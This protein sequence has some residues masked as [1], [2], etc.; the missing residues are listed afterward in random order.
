M[1]IDAGPLI[2]L[3]D[4]SDHF[5]QQAISFV[6]FLQRPLVTTWPVVT[7]TSHMLSFNTNV[8]IAFLE[9]INRGGLQ[10][11][12]IDDEHASFN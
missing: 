8:Q 9:W 3:F 12:Q 2:A 10:I 5:H 6:R 1:L 7:E 4:R 11:M